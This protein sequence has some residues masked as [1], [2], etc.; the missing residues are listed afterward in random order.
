MEVINDCSKSVAK[1]LDHLK[2][3]PRSDDAFVQAELLNG[4]IRLLES[5]L[6][7]MAKAM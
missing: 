3:I 2:E 4:A 6:D 7:T 1:A 5:A